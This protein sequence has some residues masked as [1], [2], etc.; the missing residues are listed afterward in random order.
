VSPEAVILNDQG[1]ITGWYTDAAK[2]SK[3][4]VRFEDGKLHTFAHAA[5][6]QTIPTGIND[7]DV[8]TGYYSRGSEIV[9]FIREP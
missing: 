3:G 2:V 4:F 6:K 5:S 7:R 8:I 1:T 9:G